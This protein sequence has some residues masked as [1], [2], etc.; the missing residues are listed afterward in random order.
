MDY[1]YLLESILQ[2]LDEGIL[3]VDTQAN[4]TFYNEPATDIAGITEN[5]AI[6]KNILDI[7]PDLTLETSTFYQV[8]RTREPVIDFVQTYMNFQGKKV[9]TLTSTIP[10]MRDDQ[11]VGALEIY[12]DL[13]QVKELSEKIMS[14]QKELFKRE[15]NDKSFKG[16]G[17]VYSM[18]DIIG[19]SHSIR[20]LK[21]KII[22]I[23]DSSSPILIYGETGTGKELFVQALHNASKMRKNK[24]FIAQNCAALPKSLLE[25]ILFG[26]SSGSFTGAKDKPGLF[27]LADGGTLFLDEVNSMDIELQGKLLRVL[28]DGVVRR[29]GGTKTTTV[30][31]RIIASTNEEPLT[32]VEKKVLRKDLYYRLNVISLNIPPLR[33]R[34]ED[35]PILV[36]YFI[37]QYNDKLFKNIQSAAPEVLQM[38]QRYDWPGNIR[39]LKYSIESIM[40]FIDGEIIEQDDV[41]VNI[42]C[43][44]KISQD[45]KPEAYFEE[46]GIPLY[47]AMEQY[48]ITLIG[49]AIQ[50]ANGNCAKAARILNIPRQTLHNKIK[51][52][53]ISWQVIAE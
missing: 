50:K 51:K 45:I 18:K 19:N 9:S 8:L 2:N 20:G 48:E 47:E 39:E 30:D 53:N 22:K 11:I 41:P 21:E 26:T 25:S 52:Y 29:I 36:D 44:Y 49:K 6:G 46:G 24:P 32:I 12:R 17:T 7:F 4:V 1:K 42:T 34:K 28:Q 27:E 35:I 15:A 43:S 14:L 10:L 13:T 31:V 40:N 16:N 37:K 23:A 5:E 33:E 3:V 38:F